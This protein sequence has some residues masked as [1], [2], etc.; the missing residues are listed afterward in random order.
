MEQQ[1]QML[2]EMTSE[3]YATLNMTEEEIAMIPVI[4]K[5]NKGTGF[6]PRLY[7]KALERAVDGKVPT[8]LKY[9]EMCCRSPYEIEHGLTYT[10]ATNGNFYDYVLYKNR[11]YV[12]FSMHETG[13][14]LSPERCKEA[15]Q[16]SNKS[17]K[18][19][20]NKERKANAKL[21]V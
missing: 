4:A 14:K 11:V 3:Q 18:Y 20:Q 9:E 10:S 21:A 17:L 2:N 12:H 8:L 6:H 1:M 19:F 7:K 15:L 5:C 13:Y 16:S